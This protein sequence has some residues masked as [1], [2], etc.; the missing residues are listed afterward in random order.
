VYSPTA[1]VRKKPIEL[2]DLDY[3]VRRNNEMNKNQEF[4]RLSITI[5]LL[6]ML[7]SSGVKNY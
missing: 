1:E 3:G 7:P 4:T 6:K 2:I 5:D